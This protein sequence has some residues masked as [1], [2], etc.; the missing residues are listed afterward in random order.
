MM[1]ITLG[2]Y[3]AITR[4][5]G[6]AAGFGIQL[7]AAAGAV[8]LLLARWPSL[9]HALHWLGA[10]C[11][12]YLGWQRVRGSHAA[13]PTGAGP[14]SFW[15]VAALQFLNHRAW[16]ISL[17]GATLLLPPDLEQVLTGSF[18]GTI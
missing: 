2:P 9:Y 16:L 10:G 17:T 8:A 18:P 12:L 5:L 15:E 13:G 3:H 6:I 7:V 11:A 1:T 4:L 14:L